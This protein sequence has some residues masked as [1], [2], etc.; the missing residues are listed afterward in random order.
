[1]GRSERHS[2]RERGLGHSST[3]RFAKSGRPGLQ[4]KKPMVLFKRGAAKDKES[5]D[6][7]ISRSAECTQELGAFAFGWI[8]GV[9]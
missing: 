6:F 2:D 1:M 7:D 5:R 8:K 3:K 9:T 4:E